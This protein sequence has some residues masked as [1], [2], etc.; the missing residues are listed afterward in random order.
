M[1]FR[2]QLE[3]AVEK[4]RRHRF[5]A[6]LVE[7]MEAARKKVLDMVPPSALVGVANSVTVRQLGLIGALTKRGNPVVDPVSPSYGLVEFDEEKFMPTLLK[8]TLAADVFISGAN[9]VTMDGKLIN[10]DGLG[11]RIAGIIFGARMS[12]VIAGRNKLVQNVDSAIFRI[13]NTITPALAKRRELP[14]PCAKAGKCIDCN[15]PERACNI[16]V[17]IE[18]KPPLTDLKVIMVDDDLGLGWD[19]QWPQEY[20][21]TIKKKYEQ[22]DWPYVAAWQ[23]YKAKRR[24]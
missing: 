15:V 6:V 7:N 17:V 8:A 12:I 16:T 23:K 13:R 4:L 24:K 10:T 22:F 2:K 9:A 5:D 11:N 19:P 21:D 18:R 1:D 14:L 20:I 3:A